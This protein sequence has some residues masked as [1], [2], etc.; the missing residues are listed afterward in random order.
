M[1]QAK[2]KLLQEEEVEE[3]AQMAPIFKKQSQQSIVTFPY[4]QL[5]LA[6]NLR[7]YYNL[8]NVNNMF[9]INVISYLKDHVPSVTLSKS[10]LIQN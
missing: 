1:L 4:L 8:R 2:Q 5:K 10:T 7:Q 6:E 3:R 9:F